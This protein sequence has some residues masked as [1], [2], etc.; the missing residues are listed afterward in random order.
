MGEVLL[1]KV[2][3]AVRSKQMA[4]LAAT[5]VH[6]NLWPGLTNEPDF[7]AQSVRVRK[8]YSFPTL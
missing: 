2:T 3:S 6:V 5:L 7:S 4:V 1:L 8:I